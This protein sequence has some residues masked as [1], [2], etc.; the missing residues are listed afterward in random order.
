M[1]NYALWDYL[2]VRITKDE[3]NVDKT[4]AGA[5]HV[6]RELDRCALNYEK[7]WNAAPDPPASPDDIPPPETDPSMVQ[8]WR[9][10]DAARDLEAWQVLLRSS[11]LANATPL[12]N[13]D[14]ALAADVRKKFHLPDIWF[15]PFKEKHNTVAPEISHLLPFS[16]TLSTYNRMLGLWTKSVRYIRFGD[17][18]GFVPCIHSRSGD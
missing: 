4:I 7:E 5:T 10:M 1:P 9:L 14:I 15:T 16:R 13:S 12:P 11:P 3:N 18:S 17:S 8:K 6:R 2:T